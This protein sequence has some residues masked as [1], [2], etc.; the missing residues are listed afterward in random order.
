MSE[1]YNYARLT[2]PESITEEFQKVLNEFAE[3]FVLCGFRIREP[4]KLSFEERVAI[5]SARIKQKQTDFMTFA[6]VLKEVMASEKDVKEILKTKPIGEHLWE[7]LE[8]AIA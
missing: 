8:E 6:C 3:Q 4:D 7:I 1:L 2:K 5:A